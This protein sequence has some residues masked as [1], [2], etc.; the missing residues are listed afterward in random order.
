M[1]HAIIHTDQPKSTIHRNMY[2]HFA[3][4]LSGSG[5]IMRTCS[6]YSKP[7]FAITDKQDFQN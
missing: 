5:L 4:H 3:E 7:T 6:G 1:P 2:G